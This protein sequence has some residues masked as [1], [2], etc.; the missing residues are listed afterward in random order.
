M[1]DLEIRRTLAI[2]KHEFVIHDRQRNFLQSA[3]TEE[4]PEVAVSAHTGRPAGITNVTPTK[5][6]GE[7][8]SSTAEVAVA[9]RHMT[10]MHLWTN[11][12]EKIQ[13][14]PPGMSRKTRC[15]G[16]VGRLHG[17][18]AQL[19]TVDDIVGTMERDIR[20]GCWA[21]EESSDGAVLISGRAPSKIQYADVS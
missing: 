1:H 20:F 16:R 5:V 14:R 13:T 9:V 18:Q 19:A 10:K 2:R 8:S 15:E 11:R 6:A 4:S 21:A 12:W 7:K 3:S 17:L